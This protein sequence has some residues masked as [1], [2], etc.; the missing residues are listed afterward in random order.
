MNRDNLKRSS[1]DRAA[2][3]DYGRRGARWKVRVGRLVSPLLLAVFMRAIA[4]QAANQPGDG[5]GDGDG[6][7]GGATPTPT[8]PPGSMCYFQSGWG[9]NFNV[10]QDSYGVIQA[11]M[12]ATLP[13]GNSYKMQARGVATGAD[14]TTTFDSGWT[15]MTPYGDWLSGGQTISD[16]L[17]IP[18]GTDMSGGF[19]LDERFT[20]GYGD[21]ND[22]D[23]LVYP[24]DPITNTC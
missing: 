23:G 17:S 12:N 20:D 22:A 13:G 14:G 24:P 6:G 1:I 15:D 2:S 3:S 4:A 11:M 7:G 19:S 16:T 10:I 5:G 21:T 9:S 8:A 18:G